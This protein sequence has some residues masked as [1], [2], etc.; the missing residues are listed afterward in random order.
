[1]TRR[2]WGR[3]VALLLLLSGCT[4]LENGLART[5][6]MGWL[7]WLRFGCNTDCVLSPLSCIGERLVLDM[8]DVMAVEG[9]RDAGYRFVN[10]DDCW[11][12]P[13]RDAQARLQA[14]ARRFPRGVKWL[15]DYVSLLCNGP[16]TKFGLTTYAIFVFMYCIR[17][18]NWKNEKTFRFTA[19]V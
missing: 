17:M 4:A 12:A 5:P 14:D 11:L 1:M 2:V 10:L 19:K 18:V 13:T 7:S 16:S 9:F 8:A 15:A 6:P 3:C